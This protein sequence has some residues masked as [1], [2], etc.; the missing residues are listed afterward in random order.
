MTRPG[1]AVRPGEGPDL[2]DDAL[3]ALI[4]HPNFDQALMAVAQRAVDQYRASWL[5]NRI[6]SDRGRMVSAFMALDL[7]FAEPNQAGFT[8]VR[9]REEAASYGFASPGRVTAWAATMR[10]MGLLAPG[11]P[12]RPQRMLPT[13][14]FFAMFRDRV[15]RNWRSI[16][17]VHPPS[18][19][20]IA[21]L[22]DDSFLA[23]LA[24]GYMGPF[25]NGQRVFDGLPEL[26][27][28]ADREAG[29]CILFS[30][31]LRDANGDAIAIARLARDFS[32]SRA[33]IRAILQAAEA[34]GML[35]RNGPDGAYRLAPRFK[36][37]IS[38]FVAA[39]FQA[40]IFAIDRALALSGSRDAAAAAPCAPTAPLTPFGGAINPPPRP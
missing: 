2:G 29:I 10:L 40:H 16:A 9:F 6:L 24:A 37:W 5:L 4:R 28:I 21:R 31:L 30:V 18:L 11:A 39:L 32:V 26:A 27:E 13:G 15:E 23:H 34:L 12:G 36:D 8:L 17:L 38:R 20:A 7:H 14:K 19:H 33:H 25:R 35:A 22:H 3:T 1:S